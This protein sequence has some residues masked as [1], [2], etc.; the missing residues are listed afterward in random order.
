MAKIVQTFTQNNSMR[1]FLKNFYG[2]K[3]TINLKNYNDIIIWRHE[4]IFKFF[5][6][7]V[8]LLSSLVSDAS[9]MSV[10]LLVLE[11]WQFLFI[12]DL[13]KKPQIKNTPVWILCNIWRLGWV[14]DIKFG[15][16]VSITKLLNAAKFQ[17]Y[18]QYCFWVIKGKPTGW[19]GE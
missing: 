16:S 14:R 11:L 13:A 8:F 17:I 4:A 19:M 3:L 9:F 2:S 6:V 10:S 15:M 7:V 5:K 18:I 12:R 1:A